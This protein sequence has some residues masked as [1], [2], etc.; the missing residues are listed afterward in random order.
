MIYAQKPGNGTYSYSIAWTEHSGRSLGGT[1]T[2]VVKGDSIKILHH[3]KANV[4]GKKGDIYAL[5]SL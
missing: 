4:T 2:I 3:G 1:C 5:G